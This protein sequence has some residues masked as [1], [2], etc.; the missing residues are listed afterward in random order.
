[1]V[2]HSSIGFMKNTDRDTDTRYLLSVKTQLIAILN[3]TYL[4]Q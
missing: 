2:Y 3:A 4:I 1:M